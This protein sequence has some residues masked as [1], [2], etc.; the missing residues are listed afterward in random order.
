M[1]LSLAKPISVTNLHEILAVLE[2]H[3]RSDD[4]LVFST[5]KGGLMQAGVRYWVELE[6]Q[7]RQAFPHRDFVLVGDCAGQA[8]VAMQAIAE[9]CKAVFCETNK[10]ASEK[11]A[12]IA[13]EKG[14]IWVEA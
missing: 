9:G 6:Q 14:V 7:A 2:K 8:G 13:Q 3:Q 10:L 1:K 11:L 5:P 4:P 12:A